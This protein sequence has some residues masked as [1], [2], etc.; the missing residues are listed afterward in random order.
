M[1]LT[2]LKAGIWS[3][4]AKIFFLDLNTG[5]SARRHDAVAA[6]HCNAGARDGL[7]ER[8]SVQNHQCPINSSLTA[9]S[10]SVSGIHYELAANMGDNLFR[11]AEYK[12][13]SSGISV[14]K[15]SSF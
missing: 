13:G 7:R 2:Q 11:G 9:H 10:P 1:N 14:G 12:N 8:I 3:F 4:I 5:C 6:H 15:L